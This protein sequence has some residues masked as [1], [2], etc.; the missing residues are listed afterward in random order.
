MVKVTELIRESRNGDCP[1]VH[2]VEGVLRFARGEDVPAGMALMQGY[3]LDDPD[4]VAQI[5]FG[6]GEGVLAIPESLILKAADAI[7]ARG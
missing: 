3:L 1:A 4:A 2:T 5:S 6:H 7:R